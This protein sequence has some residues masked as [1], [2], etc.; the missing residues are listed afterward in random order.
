MAPP[1]QPDPGAP[2]CPRCRA[3]RRACAHPGTTAAGRIPAVPEDRV[4]AGRPAPGHAAGD[5]MTHDPSNASG[6]AN[7][8]APGPCAG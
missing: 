4:T 5:G 3:G 7:T 2:A 8:G 1:P 6:N